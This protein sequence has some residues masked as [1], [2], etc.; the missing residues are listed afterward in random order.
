MKKKK[1]KRKTNRIEFES[2]RIHEYAPFVHY[3]KKNI[4]ETKS[5]EK[6]LQ[7]LM[8]NERLIAIKSERKRKR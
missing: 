1:K 2:Y 8:M 6:Y 5:Y 3:K 4:K 7:T